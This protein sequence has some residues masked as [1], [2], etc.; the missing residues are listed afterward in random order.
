[1]VRT[2]LRRRACLFVVALSAMVSACT[3][4]YESSFQVIV[5]NRAANT[6]QILADGNA[7]G[8]VLSGQSATFSL[9][10]PESNGNVYTNGVAPTPQA[11]VTF[12]AKDMRTGELSA[13]RDV[14]LSQSPPTHLTFS[15]TDF[16]RVGAT[17]ARF[18]FSPT[19]PSVNQD[20]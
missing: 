19:A 9:T 10:L 7:L 12:V 3:G 18:T 5:E 16:P 15:S 2:I 8:Q 6:I 1:M 13:D 17:V 11:Q 14:T 4:R 20:V